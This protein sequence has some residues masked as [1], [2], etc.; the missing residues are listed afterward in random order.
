MSSNFIPLHNIEG[1]KVLLGP[2]LREHIPLLTTWVNDFQTVTLTGLHP[3][4]VPIE[5]EEDWYRFATESSSPCFAIYI[6]QT[7]EFIGTTRL[8]N[9]DYFH[10]TGEFGIMLGPQEHLS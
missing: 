8:F 1:T 6:K 4:P 7:G 9:L 2:L 5:R 3:N 10:R